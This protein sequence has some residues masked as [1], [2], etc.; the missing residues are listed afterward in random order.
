PANLLSH[1]LYGGRLVNLEDD[2]PVFFGF[3]LEDEAGHFVGGISDPQWAIFA[4]GTI[5]LSQSKP[6]A[7]EPS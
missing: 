1:G 2:T 6:L 3:Q 5:R 4:N 7:A